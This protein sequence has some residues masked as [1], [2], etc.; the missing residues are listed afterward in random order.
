[1]L[2]KG[3]LKSHLVSF[4]HSA[5]PYALD[6]LSSFTPE[7]KLVVDPFVWKTRN[8]EIYFRNRLGIAGGV[9][10]D[11]S[12]IEGWRH[13]GAGFVEVGTVTPKAQ[14]PNPGRIIDRD[15]EL[16]AL[17]NRMG[18]P[19]RGG[20]AVLESLREFRWNESFNHRE[21]RQR[22]PVFVNIGKN[23]ETSLERAGDDYCDLIR[24]FTKHGG[25][26][27]FEWVDAFVI[28]ISS[29]NTKGLR[30]LFNR[31]RLTQFLAPIARELDR[32][33][34]PGLLKLSP[35]LDRESFENAV[36]VALD[37][38]LDGFVATNT[39]VAREAGSP[40]PAEGGVSGAPLTLM[41]REALKTLVEVLGARRSGKLIVSVGGVMNRDEFKLRR[42]LGADLVQ[43]YAAL[44]FQGPW[45]FQKTLTSV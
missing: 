24:L 38:G 45:F 1:M 22:L 39:T 25:R 14:G 32:T 5:A 10:K 9:D 12:Q 17:W 15:D 7:K 36:H 28:N 44:A 34:S 33:V 20:D 3:P 40:F 16:Q 13:F 8:K 42:E 6:V 37:L 2:L 41:S 19:S 27:S 30:D 43:A 35:D 21:C 11:G 29:P 18:F 23:R 4:L 26:E 31:D